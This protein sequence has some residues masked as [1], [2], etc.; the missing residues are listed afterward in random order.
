MVRLLEMKIKVKS[1]AGET[2]I[3]RFEERKQ[4]KNKHEALSAG[5]TEAAEK[6]SQ[7]Y[8]R[9]RSHRLAV[10]RPATR[11]NHLAY[12][13]LRGIPYSDIEGRCATAPNFYEIAKH[14][15]QFIGRLESNNLVA[16]VEEALQHLGTQG[17]KLVYDMTKL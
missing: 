10:V 6:I 11:H 8:N 2:A 15:R 3:I 16:W 12:G 13:F 17:F 1:L 4:L 5:K 9:L 14:V 7:R